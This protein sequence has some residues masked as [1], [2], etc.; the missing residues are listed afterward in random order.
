[1]SSDSDMKYVIIVPDGMGDDPV[2]EL[3]NR[4]PLEASATPWMDAMAGVSE[5]GLTKTAPEG[6][7]PGSDVANLAVLGYPPE[8]VY[9][10][11]APFEAAAMGVALG[12][13]DL[14]FRLNLVSLDDNY[15]IM[16]DHSANHISSAEA[17]LIVNSLRPHIESLG[18]S[19]HQGV[20]Y[21]HL[22]VWRHGPD[23]LVTTPPHDFPDQPIDR[24]LP[25]GP[26]SEA[27]LKL[28]IMSWK[29]LEHHPVNLE[30]VKGGLRPANS[31]WTW[32][33]GKR[34]RMEPLTRTYGITGSVVAAV[35]LMKGI[36][37]YAGL[38]PVHVPGATGYVDTNYEGKVEAALNALET[39]DLVF[40]HVEAPDEASHSG[41][42]ALKIQAIEDFDRRVVGPLLEGLDR[43]GP[44]RLML[45]PDHRT[46]VKKRTHTAD[47]VPFL[48]VDSSQWTG[49][50]ETPGAFS[51]AGAEAAGKFVPDASDLIKVLFDRKD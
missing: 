41:D 33:Q 26:E 4:T 45:M 13:D 19:I 18:F 34:P 9:S 42:L 8:K 2:P 48:I 31:V 1:M 14:A 11:R 49:R 20:S 32:G 7:A 23:G 10:G 46:P 38:T 50:T 43:K 21:R 40:L 28:L 16:A 3:N 25:V 24:R 35:D 15:T 30:R 5:I 47:P 12:P 6:M 29:V 22:L 37:V 39:Q 44:W 17:E 27:L 51:E 36:G